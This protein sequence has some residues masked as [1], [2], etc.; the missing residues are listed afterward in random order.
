MNVEV[1]SVERDNRPYY[2]TC[3]P[4]PK[5]RG[6][7]AIISKGSPQRGDQDVVICDLE[8]CKNMKAAKKWYARQMKTRPWEKPS[9]SVPIPEGVGKVTELRAQGGKL[10]AETESETPFIVP[11][12]PPRS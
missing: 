1:L 3:G 11:L 8:I 7:L 6:I 10:V 5:G 12:E 2:L 9:H 4:N